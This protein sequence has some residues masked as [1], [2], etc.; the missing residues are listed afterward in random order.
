M[1]GHCVLRSLSLGAS[2]WRGVI[3]NKQR[4]NKKRGSKITG[5]YL[6]SI[7]LTAVP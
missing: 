3:L 5:D 4:L 7:S 1:T 6:A 2:L